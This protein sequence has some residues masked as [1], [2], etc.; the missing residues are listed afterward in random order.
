MEHKPVCE[1]ARVKYEA[2]LAEWVAKYPNYCRHCGGTGSVMVTENC[3]PYGESSDWLYTFEVICDCVIE[4][5]C[6]RCGSTLPEPKPDAE[7]GLE[8]CSV[9]GWD[10]TTSYKEQLHAPERECTCWTESS[11]SE[12]DYSGLDQ[13]GHQS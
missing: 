12:P 9:C 13:L 6:P 5:R 11:D 8:R 4:G 3:A 2:D 10:A 7:P 1:A